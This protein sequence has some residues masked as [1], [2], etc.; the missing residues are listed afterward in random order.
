MGARNVTDAGRFYPLRYIYY[1]QGVASK[2]QGD[3]G[4]GIPPFMA[5]CSHYLLG[6]TMYL[7]RHTL[8]LLSYP[9]PV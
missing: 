1:Y 9:K 8:Y 7:V 5:S 6:R 3:G 2:A 4:V